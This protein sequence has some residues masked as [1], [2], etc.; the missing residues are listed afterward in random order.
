[1]LSLSCDLSVSASL[2]FTNPLPWPR[3]IEK[4]TS[5]AHFRISQE[6]VVQMGSYFL[7]TLE[8][9]EFNSDITIFITYC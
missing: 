8:L 1:M 3:G 6:L 5:F 2:P 4:C 9:C 7:S